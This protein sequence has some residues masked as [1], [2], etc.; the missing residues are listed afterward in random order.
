M[1]RSSTRGACA[2]VAGLLAGVLLGAGWEA[3]WAQG[4]PLPAGAHRE[5]VVGACIICHS[6]ETMAQQRLDRP[7]WEAI[8]DRMITYGAPITPETR[9]LILEYLVTRLGP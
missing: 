8:L 7:T 9:P 1:S 2:L 6:L 3:L 4:N 5:L